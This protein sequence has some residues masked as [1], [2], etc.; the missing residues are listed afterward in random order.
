MRIGHTATEEET[1]SMVC[2]SLTIIRST[3]RKGKIPQ[4]MALRL[5]HGTTLPNKFSRRLQWLKR[6]YPLKDTR[7][8]IYDSNSLRTESRGDEESFV[9]RVNREG[10]ALELSG[11]EVYQD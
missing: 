4:I 8:L 10:E 2:R 7:R 1:T 5:V 3:P 9:F 6:V 11:K